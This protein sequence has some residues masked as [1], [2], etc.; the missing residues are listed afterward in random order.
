MGLLIG[1][2][3][4]GGII[5]VLSPCVLPVLPIIFSGSVAD[6]R[7]RPYGIIAGFIFSFSLLTLSMT[8][9][10]RVFDID[11]GI[12]RLA[13]AVIIV[14]FAFV[15]IVP[16]FK[17]KFMVFVNALLNKRKMKSPSNS[18][19]N[20]FFAGMLTGFSLGAVW[21]PCVGPIMASVI[22]LAISQSIDAG[23]VFITLSYAAGTSIPLFAIMKGGRG[24]IQRFPALNRNLSKIQRSFGVLML[25]TGIALFTGLDRDFQSWILEAFPGYGTGLTSIEDNSGIQR[26]LKRR[27]NET[28]MSGIPD[29]TGSGP[30]TRTSGRWFNS[31]SLTLD[32]LKG[33]VV[34]VDFWTYSC[35]N[36]LRTIPYLKIW[37]ERYAEKGLVIVG[38]HTPEFAFEQDAG[39]L[40]NAIKDLGI[41]WPVVQDND[42]GIWNA[43]SNRYWP[44]HYIFDKK[45]ELV[46][47]HFGE[48]NYA[49]TEELIQKLL[50][51]EDY[52]VAETVNPSYE[53]LNPET[54]LGSDRG[55]VQKPDGQ[56]NN[57]FILK[58][59]PKDFSWGLDGY[60]NQSAEYI[61]PDK[62]GELVLH[63]KAKEVYLVISRQE[64]S[65]ANINVSF[66]G[67][68]VNTKDVF[69]GNLRLGES[70]LYT[71]FSS[72]RLTE[73]LLT[74]KARG[75]VKLHAFTFM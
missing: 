3:F 72:E 59:M 34:L 17:E 11:P 41:S 52:K 62:E 74:L 8:L 21:T 43:F 44:A 30:L 32:E 26:E 15:L 61:M 35:I 75:D 19:S 57:H 39:N 58:E 47:M 6:G 13:A 16:W 2:A 20:G 14:I 60:W 9:I 18:S 51:A 7:S 36:C 73:G 63:F 64:E 68:P 33:K 37:N 45:G 5:T 10:V 55:L 23:A 46:S 25:V 71:V 24:L 66:N 22:T 69:G 53:S 29:R 50:G 38:V 27:A 1:F 12:L 42:Y 56:K 48:G 65:K 28:E 31:K 4:L 70:R 67:A 54:Y 40:K 49:E